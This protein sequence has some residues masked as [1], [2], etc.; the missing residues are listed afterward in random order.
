MQ[1]ATYLISSVLLLTVA[2]FVFHRVVAQEYLNQGRLGW[3]A[4]SLQF[5]IFLAFFFFPYIYMPP[6]WSWDWLPN[7]TWNRLAALGLELL[8]MAWAFGIMFWFGL[9]RAFGLEVKGLVSTG[10]YRFTRNPQMLGGWLM[11]LGVLVYMPSLYNLGWVLIWALIG[12]WMV[13]NEEIHLRRVFGE[14]YEHYSEK[15][16]RYLIKL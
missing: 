2:Y 11:V 10:P 1:T 15:T 14:E 6:E 12:H 9:K 4:S 13:T 5:I 3:W 7:G 8:G 16:P